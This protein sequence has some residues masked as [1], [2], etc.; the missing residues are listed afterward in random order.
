MKVCIPNVM[1]NI[2]VLHSYMYSTS[3]LHVQGVT[4]RDIN[5]L[6]IHYMFSMSIICKQ[7]LLY[8]CAR[9]YQMIWILKITAY[10]YHFTTILS[11]SKC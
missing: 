9:Y 7:K 10:L 3:S 5:I 6:F 1:H 4:K 2:A 11:L 8:R